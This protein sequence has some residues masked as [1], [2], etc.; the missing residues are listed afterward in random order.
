[1]ISTLDWFGAYTSPLPLL[2]ESEN[3]DGWMTHDHDAL[4]FQPDAWC[5]TPVTS[6]SHADDSWH[7]DTWPHATCP[8]MTPQKRTLFI[9]NFLNIWLLSELA[10]SK[11]LSDATT[12]STST[13]DWLPTLCASVCDWFTNFA[14]ELAVQVL[15]KMCV[16]TR[17]KWWRW[18]NI[19]LI[20]NFGNAKYLISSAMTNNTVR[21]TLAIV[22]VVVI[23]TIIVNSA[24]LTNASNANEDFVWLRW[25]R[26]R[27]STQRTAMRW[28]GWK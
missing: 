3:D 21:V 1:M 15:P 26:W 2:Q 19:P 25:R 22:V 14:D 13:H 24:V 11:A 6:S 23:I 4:G 20:S 12:I 18:H 5:L 9:F 17:Q 10:A 8:K 27:R 7:M 28:L 16:S